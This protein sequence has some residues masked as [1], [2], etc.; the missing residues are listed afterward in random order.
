[1]KKTIPVLLTIILVLSL[2]SAVSAQSSWQASVV[3]N[4]VVSPELGYMVGW[5]TFYHA[6][7]N[8][9]PGDIYPTL[10]A[11][12]A[13]N[14]YVNLDEAHAAGFEYYKT[15][16][17]GL[18][19]QI[20]AVQ[21]EAKPGQS[22][23]L[24]QNFEAAYGPYGG[25]IEDPDDSVPAGGEDEWFFQPDEDGVWGVTAGDDYV[26]NYFRIDQVAGTSDGILKRY[27]S[28]S[29]PWSHAYVEEDMTITGMSNV[30]DAFMMD[31]LPAGKDVSDLWWNMF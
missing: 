3:S 22:G 6:V 2:A 23:T 8:P 14:G 4:G 25:I 1:M 18:T 21:V 5:K 20:W 24:T 11:L 12:L 30:K 17:E 28:I 31:N 26:G 7:P 10:A 15:E 19:D 16:L 9:G 29:S 13:A 27:I